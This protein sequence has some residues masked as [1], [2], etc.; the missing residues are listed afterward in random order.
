MGVDEVQ[1]FQEV[2]PVIIGWR[3][4]PGEELNHL[5]DPT[6]ILKLDKEGDVTA[7]I[8]ISV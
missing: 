8:G 7:I 5:G 2:V 3:R 1:Q 4:T 6:N